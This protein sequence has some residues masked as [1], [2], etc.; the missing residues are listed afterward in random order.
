MASLL[1]FVMGIAVLHFVGIW[2]SLYE[3][4]SRLGF[5]R[6]CDCDVNGRFPV[7][8]IFACGV[9]WMKIRS[10]GSGVWLKR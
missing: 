9:F 2:D 8:V 10:L 1:C 4:V 7:S 3:V 5:A 6:F